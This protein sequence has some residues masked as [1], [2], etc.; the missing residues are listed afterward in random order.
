MLRGN[1][2]TPTILETPAPGELAQALVTAAANG[3]STT[4]FQSPSADAVRFPQ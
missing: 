2:P 3:L 4:Y 1:I